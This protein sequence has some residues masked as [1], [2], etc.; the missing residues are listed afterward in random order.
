MERA[1]RTLALRKLSVGCRLG[2]VGGDVRQM[3]QNLIFER[4][5][6]RG[7]QKPDEN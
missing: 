7:D 1:Q 6:D 5:V 3:N 4:D 2:V